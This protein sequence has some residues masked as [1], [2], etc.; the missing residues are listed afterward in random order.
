MSPDVHVCVCAL[1]LC[2]RV[3]VRVLVRE[4]F[5]K[6]CGLQEDFSTCFYLEC[7][8]VWM[9]LVRLRREGSKTTDLRQDLFDRFW[10]DITKQVPPPVVCISRN[11]PLV[12]AAN[13]TTTATNMPP[14]SPVFHPRP[15]PHA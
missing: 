3:Y 13:A 14:P 8:H 11:S 12:P 15:C 6:F 2:V 1:Y 10:E 7:L 9:L 4:Q 5:F